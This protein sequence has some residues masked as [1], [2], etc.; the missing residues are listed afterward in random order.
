MTRWSE[1][2]HMKYKI[3]LFIDA[4]RC[5]IVDVLIFQTMDFE[6][7]VQ[8]LHVL[9]REGGIPYRYVLPMRIFSNTSRSE[10]MLS[11]WS[12]TRIAFTAC[13]LYDGTDNSKEIR[14]AAID[15]CVHLRCTKFAK[16]QCL[17]SRLTMISR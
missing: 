6:Q 16:K 13:S 1:L 2:P 8:I 12:N 11:Y 5:S 14:T 7:R 17:S 15:P 3:V 4:T 9:L 10:V